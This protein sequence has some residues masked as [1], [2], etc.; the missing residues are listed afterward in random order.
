VG[1]SILANIEGTEAVII[2]DSVLPPQP[3]PVVF[4]LYEG[5][6]NIVDV[7]DRFID[8]FRPYGIRAFMEGSDNSDYGRGLLERWEKFKQEVQDA[9]A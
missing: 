3:L 9:E 1:L 4:Y 5:D 8:S 6:E 2:N 7:L